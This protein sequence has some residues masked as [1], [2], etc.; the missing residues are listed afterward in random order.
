[1][2]VLGACQGASTSAPAAATDSGRDVTTS[3]TGIPSNDAAS[4]AGGDAE[5]SFDAQEEG[6]CDP[7]AAS[8]S[9][10]S[11][12]GL[13]ADWATKTVAPGVMAYTPSYVLWSDGA[14]KS[15]WIYLPEGTTIDTSDMD[16]WTFPVGTKVWKEFRWPDADAATTYAGVPAGQR[17]ET[18]MLWKR[19]SGWDVLIYRWSA[20]ESTAALSLAGETDVLGT[21]YEVPGVNECYSCHSGRQDFLLG[22][23]LIGTGAPGAAG[24]TLASLADAGRLSAPPPATSITIPEDSTGLSAFALGYLHVNCGVS[25]HNTN[26]NAQAAAK[27]VYFKLLADQLYPDGGTAKV[28]EL[29]SY[30]TA[31]KVVSDLMP[32]GTSYVII[33]PGNADASILT[34]MAAARD[35]DAG[36]FKPMPPLVSHIPD[37]VD[38]AKVE[39]WI[40]A[41]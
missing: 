21:T 10:L 16:D 26:C 35:P 6:G 38:V 37:P 22:F 12:T 15:R 11:C 29:D 25:C 32:N 18:R 2:G 30:K 9:D 40:N 13:Y 23:D 14:Q 27:G 4:D 17:I 41:L 36:G 3:E 34:H 28:P 1:M 39:A 8:P 5:G 20:D 7:D 24:V 19:P 31:V 33:D